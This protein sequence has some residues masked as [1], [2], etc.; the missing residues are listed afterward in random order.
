M[1]SLLPETL[2]ETTEASTLATQWTRFKRQFDWVIAANDKAKAKDEMK[3]AILLRTV[4]PRGIDIYDNFNLT[5]EERKN[6]ATVVKAFDDYC[7]PR[8]NL[9]AARHKFLTMKQGEQTVD[10]FLTALRKQAREY[11]D[12]KEAAEDWILHA[13]TL[14]LLEEGTRKRLFEKEDL[15]LEK[16]I[17]IY[18]TVEGI[19]KEMAGL[20]LNEEAHAVYKRP[21]RPVDSTVVIKKEPKARGN[22]KYCG[23]SHPPWQ[24]PAF[25]KACNACGTMNHFSKVCRKKNEASVKLVDE[26]REDQVNMVMKE[27]D[28]FLGSEDAWLIRVQREGRKLVTNL[29][30]KAEGI[31]APK[32]L[33]TQLDIAATCNILSFQAYEQLGKPPLQKSLTKLN[34]YNGTVELSL[35]RCALTVMNSEK[36]VIL[37]FEMIDCN[38]LTLLSLDSCLLLQLLTVNECVDLVAGKESD[39]IAWALEQYKDIFTG[40]GKLAGEYDIEADESVRPV[41]NRP[42]RIPFALRADLAKKLDALEKQEII[43]KVDKPTPWISNLL[44]MRKPSGSI[45]VCLDP[46][47]LNKAIQ[48]NH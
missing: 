44:A 33:K 36:P 31:R 9:F 20:K 37:R 3:L 47:D 5:D 27:G 22:C 10:Q 42:R 32:W 24:C 45:R 48:K 11:C 6:Y 34:M 23:T 26:L 39:T 8:V 17:K 29:Q 40:L 19:Q 4:G 16:A 38:N 13:L 14:G 1:E 30:V 18:R 25:G 43:A 7:K 21:S 2:S 15:D 46:T 41:Q 35:G 28:M 12:F